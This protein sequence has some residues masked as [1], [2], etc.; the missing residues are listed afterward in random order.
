VLSVEL[1]GGLHLDR[2]FLAFA[3]FPERLGVLPTSI[4]VARASGD[5]VFEQFASFAG[6]AP[7]GGGDGVT[8]QLPAGGD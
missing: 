2:R 8:R 7:F 3:L 6:F 4:D 1:H 5:G